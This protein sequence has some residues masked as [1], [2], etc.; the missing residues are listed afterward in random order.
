[1]I[2]VMVVLGQEVCASHAVRQILLVVLGIQAGPDAAQIPIAC[3]T[4]GK[5][6][7]TREWC[8]LSDER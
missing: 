6:I 2:V 5:Q 3:T 4:K 7:V 1:M 8:M